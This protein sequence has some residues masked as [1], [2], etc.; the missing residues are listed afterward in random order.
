M[1]KDKYRL[2]RL[3]YILV[4][5]TSRIRNKRPLAAEKSDKKKERRT[6]AELRGFFLGERER[7]NQLSNLSW[8]APAGQLG[9]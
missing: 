9:W 5:F 8:M 2:I 4:G 1:V 3:V 6:V 7:D